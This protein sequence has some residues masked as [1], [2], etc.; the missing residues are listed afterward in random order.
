MITIEKCEG[1]ISAFKEML[2]LLRM[3]RPEDTATSA[4]V[5]ILIKHVQRQIQLDESF[6]DESLRNMEVGSN[7]GSI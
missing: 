3:V 5:Q 4:Q 1:R 2:S 7:G 6:I